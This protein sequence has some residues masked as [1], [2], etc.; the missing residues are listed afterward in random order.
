MRATFVCC[1][2]ITDAS[3]GNYNLPAPSTEAPER[4][5][6]TM[7]SLERLQGLHADLVA[8][9]EKK[10]ASLDR[11][12]SE[13]DATLSDFRRLLDRS[14]PTEQEKEAYNKGKVILKSESGE[15]EYAITD[16]F[17]HISTAL[18]TAVDLNEVEAAKLLVR[19]YGDTVAP[20]VAFIA[21]ATADYQDGR[22]LLLQSL[23]LVLQHA[24]DFE[25]EEELRLDLFQ[26]TVKEI[27]ETNKSPENGSTFISKCLAGLHNLE[28][29]YTSVSSQLQTRE[30]VGQLAGPE[31]DE[32]LEFQKISL[33]K[34]HEA[35]A[36]ILGYLFRG[37]YAGVS[38]L[39]KLCHAVQRWQKLDILL[40]HYLPAFSAAFRQFGSAESAVSLD[41]A[42]NLNGIVGI[43]PKADQGAK[44]LD[45]FSSILRIW[46]TVEYSSFFSP[47]HDH[48]ADSKACTEQ[49]MYA[50]KENGLKLL[51]IVCSNIMASEWRHPARQEM[52]NFLMRNT[53]DLNVDTEQTSEYFRIML[54]E[55]IEAFI[56]SF[57]SNMPDSIRQLKHSEDDLRL[58][59]IAAVQAGHQPDP[60]FD[61]ALPMHL[62]VF[63]VL[64]SFAFEG[65]ID[66]AEQ[67]WEDTETNLYGFLQWASK[68]QTVPRVSAFCDMLC[69]ISEG[70]EGAAS[71]HAFL[72]ED[73]VPSAL[74]RSRRVPSMNYTQLF[75]ELEL[76]ARKVHE[77]TA[78]SNLAN[79]K[80]LETDMNES[81][82]PIMLSSYLRLIAH[83]C[84]HS[85][86]ARIY[87]YNNSTMNFPNT[88]LLL[89]SGPVPPYLKA[90]IFATLEAMLTD[91]DWHRAS[92]MWTQTDEWL[93][94]GAE[95]VKASLAK[96]D[97]VASPAMASVQGSLAS[98]ATSIDQYDAF[99]CLLR[100]LL[101]PS[102]PEGVPTFSLDLGSAYRTPGIT[103]YVDFICG[104]IFSKRLQELHDN[105]QA[106]LCAFHCLDTVAIA[107]ASFDETQAALFTRGLAKS[108]SADIVTYFQRHP[109]ARFMQWVLS[110]D[111]AKP[112]MQIFNTPL[113]HVVSAASDSPLVQTLHRT[114]DVLSLVLDL[115]STYLDVVK[116]VL[117]DGPYDR[118]LSGLLSIEEHVLMHPKVI[119]DLCQYASGEHLELSLNALSLLQKLSNSAKLN[120]HFLGQSASHNRSRRIIDL[121]G[122]NAATTL[123][124]ASQALAAK[125]QISERELEEGFEAPG[126]LSKD[127]IIGFVNACLQ[128]QPELANVAHILLGCRRIGERLVLSEESPSSASLL[129]SVI[130]LVRDYPDGDESGFVSW[131]IHLKSAAMQ[132]LCQLWTSTVSSE[133]IISQLRRYQ[134]LKA[135]VSSQKMISENAQ[136]DGKLLFDAAFWFG[137]SADA[138][139]EFL[140]FR[141][142]LYQYACKE[143]RD[144]A[145]QRLTSVLKQHLQT[146]LGSDMAG[147][148]LGRANLFDLADF[149]EL[150][151]PASVPML[152]TEYFA[153]FD[154]SAFMSHDSDDKPDL[155]DVALAK[156][157]LQRKKSELINRQPQASTSVQIDQD[158]ADFEMNVIAAHLESSNRLKL[159]HDG[160]RKSLRCYADMVVALIDCWSLDTSG[161]TSFVL[162]VLQLILPKL[163][164][165]VAQESEDTVELARIADSLLLALP[166]N[167]KS[168][169]ADSRTTDAFKLDQHGL[170]QER[171]DNIITEKLFQLFR[172]SIDGILMAKGT[173]SQRTV[174]YS[175]CIQ[176]LNRILAAEGAANETN[177]KARAN[178]MDCVRSSGTRLV[179]IL[180]DDAEDG[181][182]SRL[183][184]LN[185]LALLT[186]LARTEKS[187]HILDALVKANV[188]EIIIEPVKHIAND[189]QETEPSRKHSPH[190]NC[191]SHQ[192]TFQTHSTP[193]PPHPPRST[194][195]PPPASL[196]HPPRRHH[197]PRRKLHV[198]NPGLPALPRRPRPRLLPTGHD[199]RQR[200][201]KTCPHAEHKSSS[202]YDHQRSSTELLRP[203]SAHATRHT[204]SIHLPRR[205]ERTG[206]I[207]GTLFPERLPCQYG[208]GVQKISRCFWE[209]GCEE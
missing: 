165:L 144:A 133:L 164:A 97:A 56:E 52:V 145:S 189:F 129:D 128:T 203:P 208:R 8:F 15:Q 156:E 100:T 149:L 70:P 105:P 181:D 116:P 194:H 185:L 27:L 198:H 206:S 80:I 88:L 157:A 158:Q 122:P 83:L 103:P 77:R 9:T 102:Y 180:S 127:R 200:F 48:E 162:Q 5:N 160:W 54:M 65:R 17:K 108:A 125:L 191:P 199:L 68:R 146:M 37:G 126:Y 53:N 177:R 19:D 58:E 209:S 98:L 45:P 135:L 2:H 26:R 110:T 64:I 94:N 152:T 192:L 3:S 101:L 197:H 12:L 178:S 120:N 72:L 153:S 172:A 21:R 195:A 137:R 69:S 22:D 66:A 41:Q 196:P 20:N 148:P 76:Y 93:S 175:I 134:L 38:D 142:A 67:W 11:L 89:S 155:Y 202:Q 7:D 140:E 82:S 34:Q 74:S 14:Q 119:L 86:K 171:L 169:P 55:S 10:L 59:Q 141:S 75:A 190:P 95:L 63:L 118:G 24:E 201:P 151:F 123:M 163:D 73:S 87:V 187:S 62:E 39:H 112:L 16:E 166:T 60:N 90:S 1:I 31:Y 121:L 29:R 179:N 49:L 28:E 61:R 25:I 115:Q 174:L 50:F 4:V 43:K 111:M 188:L 106:V 46:W 78:T 154:G 139:A 204:K 150:D 85:E 47:G 147:T 161:K 57:I 113:K 42:R 183:N 71:A 36:C 176:Y 99:V 6:Y 92:A 143:I 182:A 170:K 91:K 130:V 114:I 18:G 193:P 40:V 33:F 32:I 13:L 138:L 51:L 84:R 184:A 30:T 117:K 136:W 96:T 131:L 81:E 44:A 109:F 35:L 104:Q 167:H 107:L 124:S 79:R 173:S 23:R 205:S 159:A 168:E 207:P 132:L 186:S